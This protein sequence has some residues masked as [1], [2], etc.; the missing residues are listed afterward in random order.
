MNQAMN[1]LEIEN[2]TLRRIKNN[3]VKLISF[4]VPTNKDCTIKEVSSVISLNIN[5]IRALL[6]D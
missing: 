4:F 2:V 3:Q 5:E 1:T 6:E